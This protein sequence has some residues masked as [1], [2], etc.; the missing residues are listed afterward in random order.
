MPNQYIDMKG[1]FTVKEQRKS[2]MVVNRIFCWLVMRL[3]L[4]FLLGATPAFGG[5][6]LITDDT[7]TQGKGKTQVELSGQYDRDNEN[8][9]KTAVWQAQA[10]LS[11]GIIDS[12]DLILEVPYNWIS[13]KNDE[14]IRQDGFADLLVAV[15][16]RF[17]EQGG[18]SFAVKPAVT[19]PT[20]NEDLGLG[21]G[22][23]SY[24]VDFITTYAKDPWAFHLNLGIG[25]VDYK[26]EADKEANRN[27]IWAASLAV[28]YKL[29]DAWKLVANVGAERNPDVSSDTPAAFILGGFIYSVSENLDLDAGVKW[30]LTSP[31][32]DISFLAGLTFRF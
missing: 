1:E 2:L 32:P 31:E 14:T 4:V 8:G 7:G 12:V 24:G 13:T 10:Q 28:E 9:V 29:A 15:K 20:G 30:G 19:L 27:D 16:W 3:V 25:H 22:R 23:S 26:L 11:Y 21:N 18:L 5:H 6:P 17:Y